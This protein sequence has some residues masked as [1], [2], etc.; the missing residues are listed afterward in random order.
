MI[1][2]AYSYKCGHCGYEEYYKQGHGY[3]VKPQS[4]EEYVSSNQKLFHYEIHNKIEMLVAQHP[5]LMIEATFQVYKCPKCHILH[6]KVQVNL[7]DGDQLLHT[8]RF[9]C[10]KC[11][12]RLRLTNIHRLKRAT[13]PACGKKSFRRQNLGT[14]L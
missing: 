11:R 8:S 10:M 1:G 4:Y 12:S 5:G 2:H 14:L 6:G 7:S 3:L 13:C 9:K